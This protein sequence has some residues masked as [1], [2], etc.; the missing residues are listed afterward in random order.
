M[1]AVATHG[2]GNG[3]RTNNHVRSEG[4]LER[5]RQRADRWRAGGVRSANPQIVYSLCP[6]VLVVELRNHDLGRA[7]HRGCGGGARA[8]VVDDSGN[9]FEEGL[10]VDLAY[11]QTVVFAVH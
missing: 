6:V 10:L 4:T 11:S 2:G 8:A 1:R 5:A 7:S 3:L 9:P